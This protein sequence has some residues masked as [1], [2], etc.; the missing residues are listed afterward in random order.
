MVYTYSASIKIGDTMEQKE[1]QEFATY[2]GQRHQERIG[3]Q[4]IDLSFF[5]DD[6]ILP[7]MR[8]DA[9]KPK[10]ENEKYIIRTGYVAEMENGITQQTISP[11]PRVFTDARSKGKQDGA[12]RIAT[13]GNKWVR[14]MSG[15]SSNPFEE[16]FKDEFQSGEA[17]VYVVHNEFLSKYSGDWREKYPDDIPVQFFNLDPMVV[18]TEPNEEIDGIPKRVIIQYERMVSDIKA[19]YPD[20]TPEDGMKKDDAKV[21]FILYIDEKQQYA[22]ADKKELFNRPN[23]YKFVNLAH[24]YSGWG[25]VTADRDPALLAFSRIRM[26]RDKIVEDSQMASDFQKNIHEFA[27]KKRTLYMPDSAPFNPASAFADYHPDDINTVDVIKLPMGSNRE[28]FK[29]NETQVFGADV[30][31]YRDRVKADLA[32]EYP[33]SMRGVATGSSGRQEDILRTMGLA[34]YDAPLNS[35]SRLWARAFD[36][37][38]KICKIVPDMLPPTIREEDVDSYSELRIDLKKEDPNELSRKSADGDMKYLKGIIDLETNL[39]EYQG[40]TKDEAK[41]IIDKMMA[42]DI[43]RNDP[44][45]RS[46][47]AQQVAQEMGVTDKYEQMKTQMEGGQPGGM[48]PVVNA[49]SQGGQPRNMNIKTPTGM[50][51]AGQSMNEPRMP[52][53]LG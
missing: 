38:F 26:M 24:G 18:F 3:E 37:A 40:R 45:I 49:G 21:K 14:I 22:E 5:K 51:Q 42:D 4:V 15:Y 7:L 29:V 6:Y 9:S 52:A 12:D 17:W 19:H 35:C 11:K 20:W 46:I 27:W 10:S 53:G 8:P 36:M 30:F 47:V 31:A 16:T 13:V 1:I 32:A 41:Q 34:M 33:S 2:M 28:D 43:M 44:I 39:I 48:N 25:K 50:E 23:I